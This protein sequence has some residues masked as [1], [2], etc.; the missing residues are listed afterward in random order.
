MDLPYQVYIIQS[1][2]HGRYYIGMSN[3]PDRRLQAHNLGLNTSTKHGAPWT[4][5]WQ[6]ASLSKKQ[7]ASLELEIKRRGAKRFLQGKGVL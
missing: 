1:Q 3:D 6:S 5:V 7:A 2:L 4:Q